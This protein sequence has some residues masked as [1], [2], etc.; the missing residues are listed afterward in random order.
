MKVLCAHTEIFV[1]RYYRHIACVTLV[2]I[3][4]SC[5]KSPLSVTEEFKPSVLNNEA[6]QLNPQMITVEV[7]FSSVPTN[8]IA[9]IAPLK[10]NK[11]SVINFEFDDNPA[12]VY[13][14]Y[15]YLK[16]QTYTDGTGK[17]LNYRAG[18]A[19]NSRGNYNNSDLWENYQGNL[20]KQQATEII[21][22]GWTLEN[23][24][25]Y[26]SVLNPK[27]NFGA[28]KPIAENIVENTKYVFDK[29]GFK[30][31]T[32]VVPSNDEGYLLPAFDQGII[33]TTSTNHFAGFQTFPLYGDFVDIATLPESKIHLRRDFNDKWDI[34]G[35]NEIKTKI[36]ALLNRSNSKDRMLYRIGT[37]VPDLDAFKIL[38]SHIQSS[39]KDNCWVT[40]MQEMVEYIQI[41]HKIIKKE[42]YVDGKLFITLDISNVDKET[43][44]RNVTLLIDTN[45]P[46]KTIKIHNARESSSNL[47]GLV[48]I[49]F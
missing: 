30:M 8:P 9:T 29:I 43:L 20:T 33:A 22:G 5:R 48:N 32:L 37:H 23:H 1:K 47:N 35:I 28:G 10:Y 24:G 3:S 39:S 31:R 17:E 6:V 27:T 12:L 15:Q 13:D 44:F 21:S 19:V 4:C 25:Y 16:A 49:T 7:S 11:T 46:I 36:T 34:N 45:S 26:H 41:R 38:A 18:V 42:S 2:L 40:T 14:V